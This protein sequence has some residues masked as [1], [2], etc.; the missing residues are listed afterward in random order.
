MS[1]STARDEIIL[2]YNDCVLRQSD[3]LILSGPRFLNDRIIEFYFSHLSSSTAA[4]SSQD[5]LFVPPVMAFWISNCPDSDTL[6]EVTQPLNLPDRQLVLFP[7]NDNENVEVAEGGFHWSLLAYH[8]GSNLFV[9]HDSFGGMNKRPARQLYRAV[10]GLMGTAAEAKYMEAVDSPC[11]EN[12]YDCGLFV[13]A[14]AR[15]ISGWYH[16]KSINRG[17]EIGDGS[18]EGLWFST[19]NNEKIKSGEVGRLRGEILELIRSML[20][21]KD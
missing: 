4:A 2:S 16:D 7:V 18:S 21:K 20:E 19:V 12:G 9:H 13:V 10:A 3:L 8:R 5:V 17:E 6:K 15:A 1:R 11:Q 14:I